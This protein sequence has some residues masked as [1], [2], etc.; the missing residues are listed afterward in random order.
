MEGIAHVGSSEIDGDPPISAYKEISVRTLQKI[1]QRAFFE[2]R[3]YDSPYQDT[4][5]LDAVRTSAN[6]F[7]LKVRRTDVNHG[8]GQNL[9]VA[10]KVTA[11]P[12]EQQYAEGISWVGPS[13]DG[14]YL[15][16]PTKT[17]QVAIDCDLPSKP[18]LH[19]APYASAYN[20]RFK[21][22][23]I[24]SST[25]RRTFSIVV[26]RI[27]QRQ[28]WGQ[29]LQIKWSVFG[30]LNESR[31]FITEEAVEI[32]V[33]EE[34]KDFAS[35]RCERFKNIALSMCIHPK[36]MASSPQISR[37]RYLD[38]KTRPSESF[39]V[40][41]A[42]FVQKAFGLHSHQQAISYYGQSVSDLMQ[43]GYFY[44][45]LI[46]VQRDLGSNKGVILHRALQELYEMNDVTDM[47]I[48]CSLL[49]RGASECQARKINVYNMILNRIRVPHEPQEAIEHDELASNKKKLLVALLEM[50]DEYKDKALKTVFL[51]P[52]RL[53]Y[54][55]IY[56]DC[57]AGDVE[58]HGSNTYLHVLAVA[59]G[60][61][62]SQEPLL[63]DCVKGVAAFLGAGQ[64]FVSALRNGLWADENLGKSYESISQ[65]RVSMRITRVPHN[66]LVCRGD[67]PAE[68][69]DRIAVASAADQTKLSPYLEQFAR[70]FS[71]E[72]FLPR[73][74]S[75]ISQ[76]DALFA[77]IQF[78]YERTIRTALSSDGPEI[79]DVRQWI[80][81]L[82]TNT[83]DVERAV[84]IFEQVGL[85]HS[86]I[87]GANMT[88]DSKEGSNQSQLS[89]QMSQL[90]N[91]VRMRFGW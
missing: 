27:D 30:P 65:C 29:D 72:V 43:G 44:Q 18:R 24:P 68:I 76:D 25:S 80:W 19:C 36:H 70:I 1:P 56:D 45:S 62:F 28:G 87:F 22:V 17:I 47:Q 37:I 89:K 39:A 63:D 23:L 32:K 77:A 11:P 78:V 34:V 9:H 21:F 6:E 49:Q 2:L 26:T 38:S 7:R 69:G 84:Q 20:D 58:V 85:V 88:Q 12:T 66:Q 14:G 8:W 42:K 50:V 61:C 40:F 83:F 54:T 52:S 4:F 79:E 81:D 91:Q 86:N 55:S 51:E 35:K 60:V 67:S 75:R 5:Q 3:V 82:E 41:A 57:M 15:S 10:W 13:G 53:Y 46:S 74:F 33:T 71:A 59:L 48:V 64:D 73:A 31:S 90:K 16:S